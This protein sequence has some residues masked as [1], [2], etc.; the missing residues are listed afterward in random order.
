[1]T[2][3]DGKLKRVKQVMMEFGAPSF[4]TTDSTVLATGAPERGEPMM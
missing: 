1:M 4:S 2:V 3:P